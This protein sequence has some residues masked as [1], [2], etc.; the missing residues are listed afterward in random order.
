[1]TQP[2]E[3]LSNFQ[4]LEPWAKVSAERAE[5]LQHQLQNELAAE[6]VLSGRKA[7]AV[8][9]R[10]DC[11]DVLF[12]FSD[13][14]ELVVVHLPHKR[15]LSAQAPFFVAFESLQQFVEGCMQPDHLE[16]TDDDV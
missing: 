9:V 12:L 16:Y 15:G 11:D 2:I 14:D 7:S 10:A 1:M 13:P 4:W 3:E 6:H 5:S 8:G